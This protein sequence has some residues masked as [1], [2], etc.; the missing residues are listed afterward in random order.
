MFTSFRHFAGTSYS[1]CE[2]TVKYT[3]RRKAEGPRITGRVQLP[4]LVSIL[5]VELPISY[6]ECQQGIGFVHINME[7]M[8]LSCLW[9]LN[10]T[11]KR[12]AV[13]WYH[14]CEYNDFNN[15]FFNNGLKTFP[16]IE[17]RSIFPT[18]SKIFFFQVSNGYVRSENTVIL[19]AILVWETELF[20]LLF[21]FL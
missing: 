14:R 6:P 5:I 1:N 18:L 20:W 9:K 11:I 17:Y 21:P 16:K 13:F 2:N 8:Q 15:L 7:S 19:L 3:G 12:I 10:S 4:C